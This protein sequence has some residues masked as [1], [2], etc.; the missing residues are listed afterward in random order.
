MVDTPFSLETLVG[1][2]RFVYM[3][4]IDDKYG[5]D[6]TWLSIDSEQYL[7]IG[8]QR[9][10]LAGGGLRLEEFSVYIPDCWPGPRNFFQECRGRVFPVY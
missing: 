1:V 8:W 7:G 6:H 4:K 9:W 2:P 10:W 5:Y 3:S